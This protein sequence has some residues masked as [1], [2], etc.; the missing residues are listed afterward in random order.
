MELHLI[1]EKTNKMANEM[2]ARGGK[3]GLKVA[4]V[5]TVEAVIVMR[6]EAGGTAVSIVEIER[7]E[8]TGIKAA[9][10]KTEIGKIEIEVATRA[11]GIEITMKEE[12]G[13]EIGIEIE[14]IGAVMIEGTEIR[15]KGEEVGIEA[16]VEAGNGGGGTM[17][18]MIEMVEIKINMIG[19]EGEKEI[20]D[21]TMVVW[22]EVRWEAIEGPLERGF[23]MALL[24]QDG[25]PMNLGFGM[26]AHIADNEYFNKRELRQLF[27]HV[28]HQTFVHHT[29]F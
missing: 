1:E 17:E 25:I 5:V 21:T 24:H 12:A 11:E 18:T 8:E 10:G 23:V 29:T 28:V 26:T 3:D 20:H 27:V 13:T 16:E 9:T 14:K 7:I 15:E 6:K 4:V 22:E 19:I 2:L